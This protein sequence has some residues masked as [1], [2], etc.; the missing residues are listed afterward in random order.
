MYNNLIIDTNEFY[1]RAFS[2]ASKKNNDQ[3][4]D[5]VINLT[6]H[7]TFCMILKCKREYLADDGKVWIL[8]DNPTSKIQVRKTIDQDYKNNRIRE[9]D[10]YYRGI[11]YLLLLAGNYSEQFNTIRIKRL[12]ADD[13]VP[14]VLKLCQGKSL[15][16]SADLDWTR[17]MTENV[18]WFNHDK[19][20]TQELFKHRF[21][22]TPNEDTVTLYKVLL[23]D[24]VDNIPSINGIN[25]QTALNIVKNFDDI[26]E[27]IACIKKNTEKSYL[28]SDYTK[29]TLLK[30]EQRLIKNHN[31]VYFCEVSSIE[32]S[33]ALLTGKFNSRALSILYKALNFPDNFDTR[34]E[35][36]KTSF[37]DIFSHFDEVKRK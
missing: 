13:L 25:E 34:I 21:K 20:Y 8:S 28:L 36:P 3:P 33:Q 18:D 37:G 12:E 22:F 35:D 14:E 11:D 30:N 23:G 6:I 1:K 9:S 16:C 17:C 24:M 10:G 27:V 15:L 26:F 31:L 5:V 7:L 29:Q 32:V 4:A 2:I 19:V